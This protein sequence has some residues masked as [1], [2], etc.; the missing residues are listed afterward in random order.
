MNIPY[1]I[2]ILHVETYYKVAIA[3]YSAE[4]RLITLC[5]DVNKF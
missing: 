3:E 1:R 4:F 2:Y 5:W